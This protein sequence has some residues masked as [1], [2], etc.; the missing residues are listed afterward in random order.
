MKKSHSGLIA[1]H[2]ESICV[3]FSDDNGTQKLTIDPRLQTDSSRS[4]SSESG[5][6]KPV[7]QKRRESNVALNRKSSGM[8]NKALA[9]SDFTQGSRIGDGAYGTV[10]KVQFQEHAVESRVT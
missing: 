4:S 9:R 7:A 1:C 8:K 2:N 3:P 5:K 6:G 10:F